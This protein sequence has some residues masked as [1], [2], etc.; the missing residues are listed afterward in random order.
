[1]IYCLKKKEQ[2]PMLKEVDKI[3]ATCTSRQEK[4][5]QISEE[6]TML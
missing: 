5:S 6:E 3:T 2:A 1:M 4:I